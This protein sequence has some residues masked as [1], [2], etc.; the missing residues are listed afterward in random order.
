MSLTSSVPPAAARSAMGALARRRTSS[1]RRRA[2]RRRRRP[3]SSAA[4]R[5]TAR[6][7]ADRCWCSTRATSSR[8]VPCSPVIST[9]A[10][11]VGAAASSCSTI[12]RIAAALGDEEVVGAQRTRASIRRASSVRDASAAAVHR[13]RDR[14]RATA[15][16]GARARSAARSSPRR[17][18]ARAARSGRLPHAQRGAR[19]SRTGPRAYHAHALRTS[20]SVRGP[21]LQLLDQIDV[22]AEHR[23]PLGERRR[24]GI[25]T[26]RAD[27]ARAAEQPRIAER[28]AA[29]H[30]RVAAGLLAHAEDSRRR[31]RR[32]RCRRP[33]CARHRLA[34]APDDVADRSCPRS[35]A[36]ACGR[37]R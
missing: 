30:H 23:E 37:A 9:G 13:R 20:C 22:A 18:R 3:R 27:L 34:H 36:C 6:R 19:C 1:P 7:R 10:L 31:R 21:L 29:D 33:A 25:G 35:P 15:R 11:A 24:P 12:A 2:L 28:A 5:R 16:A 17:A 26:P 8:P 4:P 32:R 14:R